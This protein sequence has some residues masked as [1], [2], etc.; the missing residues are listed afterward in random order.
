MKIFH[1]ETEVR[2]WLQDYGFD[3]ES[4]TVLGQP[5]QFEKCILSELGLYSIWVGVDFNSLQVYIYVEYECGGEVTRHTA[6]FSDVDVD[7]EE[8]FM[9]ALEELVSYYLE[10]YK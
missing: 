4:H 9:E 10:T 8:P 3:R 7:R 6:D 1:K 5:C 2:H